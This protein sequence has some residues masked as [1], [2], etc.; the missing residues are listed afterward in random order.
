MAT[1]ERGAPAGPDTLV[2]EVIDDAEFPSLA[3]VA[4]AQQAAFRNALIKYQNATAGT[5]NPSAL[6]LDS[7]HTWSEVLEAVEKASSEYN[8]NPGRWGKIRKALRRFGRTNTVFD[9]WSS[10]LPAQSEY[11]SIVC[12]GLKLI[13]GAAARLGELRGEISDALEELPNL[14]S[15]TSQ[16]IAIF[17][18]PKELEQCAVDLYVATLDALE[19]IVGWFTQKAAK[20]AFSSLLKQD[21]YQQELSSKIDNIHKCSERFDKTAQLCSYRSLASARHDIRAHEKLSRTQHD[22]LLSIIRQAD[23]G[24]R[25]RDDLLTAL[26][27]R[28]L[29]LEKTHA[30]FVGSSLF[31]SEP[32]EVDRLRRRLTRPGQAYLGVGRLVTQEQ[33][34]T[35][36]GGLASFHEAAIECEK[37]MA[38]VAR[39]I[40]SLPRM[41]QDRTA[42]MVQSRQFQAWLASPLSEVLFI[43]DSHSTPLF[44]S[45]SAFLCARLAESASSHSSE[46][47]SLHHFCREHVDQAGSA[48]SFGPLG[49]LRSLIGQLLA[50]VPQLEVPR[51]LLEMDGRNPATSGETVEVLNGLFERLLLQLP[52]DTVVICVIDAV[53]VF[54]EQR[55]EIQRDTRAMIEGLVRVKRFSELGCCAFKLLFACPWKSKA[56]YRALPDGEDAVLWMPGH[57]APQGGLST[58]RWNSMLLQMFAFVR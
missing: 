33:L 20:K 26:A 13:C 30:Q 36:T 50:R 55:E 8:G 16:A 27:L 58:T 52:A 24:L 15:V 47:I 45:P 53:N 49:V 38:K 14:F 54:E 23:D 31:A 18:S 32:I 5:K 22:E 28:V 56:L 41:A 51:R 2:G 43:N 39:S 40:E 11:F 29:A 17:D 48:K 3:S 37:D 35:F 44:S 34:Q 1:S 19:H 12:G 7:V 6:D 9:A 4:E 46:A 25:S 10:V 57:V 42:A 21:A